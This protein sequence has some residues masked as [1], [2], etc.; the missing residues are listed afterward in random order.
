MRTT[1]ER[2]MITITLRQILAAGPCYDPRE[3]G[4]IPDDFDLDAAMEFEFIA[5]RVLGAEDVIWC[6]SA[7]PKHGE[8]QR[9]F[10]RECAARVQHLVGDNGSPYGSPSWTVSSQAQRAITLAE[11]AADGD[12]AFYAARAAVQAVD[13]SKAE[14]AWQVGRVLELTGDDR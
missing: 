3:A 2:P 9:Q 14:R 1:K 7:L 5:E 6:F 8:L 12:A 4:I 10:A 11:L 13:D